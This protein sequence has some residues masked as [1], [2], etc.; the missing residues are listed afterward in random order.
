MVVGGG[1]T[2]LRKVKALLAHGAEV[3]VI[4]SAFCTEL[5]KLA[6]SRDIR[7]IRRHYQAGDLK[8]AFVV[9]AATDDHDT[10]LRVAREAKKTAVLVNIVDDPDMSDFI[11][12]SY[13]CRGDVTIAVS[14]AGK[15]PALARKI[16]TKLEKDFGDEYGPL[17][18]LVNEVRTE[19]KQEGIK[20]SGDSWQK[21]LD[22]D[23]IVDLLKKMNTEK[24]KAVLLNN[25]KMLQ[26]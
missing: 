12:P 17:A 9:I 19:L 13:M 22:L 4:S 11:V 8:G 7:V 10:N 6:D 21:A 3:E 14:T 2:A 16:R 26:E 24:A 5:D 1:R 15:S 25:L 20:V 18:L 23:L